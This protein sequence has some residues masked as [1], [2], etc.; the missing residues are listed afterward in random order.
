MSNTGA[1]LAFFLPPET[2]NALL[3]AVGAQTGDLE[4]TKTADLHLTVVYL[5]EAA[6]LP[7]EQN[8]ALTKCLPMLTD[9]L[10]SLSGN[11]N[12][13]GRFQD[14]DPNALYANVDAPGLAQLRALLIYLARQCG[15]EPVLE[16]G[17][18]PHVTLAYLPAAVPTPSIQIAPIPCQIE[19]ITLAIGDQ[20]T[21]YPLR[22][23]LPVS[24]LRQSV[25]EMIS[26]DLPVFS[27]KDE[28]GYPD[29][30]ISPRVD[31]AALTAGDPDPLFVT[32]PLGVLG[33]VSQNGLVY[34]ET[35]LS[36]IEQQ[37][38]GKV[39]RQGHVAESNRS[40]EF[41]NDVAIWVGV[42][43]S[44]DTLLGKSYIYPGTAFNQ[45]VRKRKAAG[46]TLSNSIWGNSAIVEMPD[47]SRRSLGLELESIDFV[48]AER[49][50]LEALGGAIVTTSEMSSEEGTPMT[51]NLAEA[52]DALRQSVANMQPDALYE[53][54][55]EA[56]RQHCAEMRLKEC[57]GGKVYEMLSEMHREHVTEAHS[58]AKNMKRV[59][60]EATTVSETTVAEMA[61]QTSEMKTMRQQIAEMQTVIKGY[62][63]DEFDRSLDDTVNAYFADWRV[64][65][66]SGKDKLNAV[67][68]NL[69]LLTVSEMAGS[70]KPEDIQAAAEKAWAN[71]KPLAELTLASLAGPGAFVGAAVVSGPGAAHGFDPSTG[72]YSPEAV[73]AA[74]QRTNI[75]GGREG[76][77]I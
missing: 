16:H 17:Y 66:E 47:G 5:G 77:Q 27:F 6:D 4:L 64:N 39:A 21:V 41:P 2:G 69:R 20:Q 49:A 3:S 42:L 45:M 63:R 75:H 1:M 52:A 30:P 67:K 59:P 65:T 7:P 28:S 26:F 12:G 58:T 53:C 33:G 24:E 70:T 50:S 10:A 22:G 32:R 61:S 62:Q 71:I 35:L 74:V 25:K 38:V 44:G 57:D 36:E 46:G 51:D 14:H 11:L 73:T 54:L 23:L 55:S 8:N 15:I 40:W 56:Q 60:K 9:Q 29:V 68:K 72:R 18:S 48:P 34:D 76:R 19:A 31:L 37:S 43:R 13:I